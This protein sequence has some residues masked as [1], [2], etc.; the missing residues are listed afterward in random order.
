MLTVSSAHHDTS[1]NVALGQRINPYYAAQLP[2]PINA[3]GFGF[4][5]AVK[6][7]ILADGGRQ[8]YS[9]KMGTAHQN[10][11]LVVNNSTA[12]P[13][14]QR[15]AAPGR[16]GGINSV[17]F[18]CGTS[19]A[20]AVVSRGAGFI[21]DMLEQLENQPGGT[22]I[23]PDLYAVLCKTLLVHT[24]DWGDAAD[25]LSQSLQPMMEN[26]NP[27][28]IL[29]RLLGFGPIQV[30]KA[31]ECTE[32]RATLIG[33]GHLRDGDAHVYKVPLPPSLSGNGTWRRMTITLGWLT[34][35]NPQHSKYR[36][37]A[38]WVEPPQDKLGIARTQADWRSVQ[39]G[40]IQ[41][42]ILEGEKA[43]AF[44]DGAVAS[45]HVNCRQQAGK[46]I[47]EVPYGL[48][49]TIEVAEGIGIPIYDEIR[50]RIRARIP[51]RPRP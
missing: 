26:E 45:I 40:T 42:E 10:A 5:R 27:K 14:G 11:T 16:N 21:Q 36:R 32:S 51:V 31:L 33:F 25:V 15:V 24:A 38:L 9:E 28:Q 6:P 17:R 13:P 37:A 34:P 30:G 50:Q 43:T 49:V 3:L 23:M 46:L 12:T 41:H 35:I 2:S 20:T 1:G 47:D 29:S 4:L 18:M 7:E 22:N 8:L 48:A 39:R 44:H 19:N